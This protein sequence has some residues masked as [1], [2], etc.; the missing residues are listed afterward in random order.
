MAAQLE[1]VQ[2]T[3]NFL[4][5]TIGSLIGRS[6]VTIARHA[7]IRQ[8]LEIMDRHR[9]GSVVVVEPDTGG[10]L[11]I[12]TLQDVLT[13]VALPGADTSQ[14]ISS[15]MT[16]RI[17]ALPP[18]A[19]VQE[20]ML[21]M[22]QHG[23]QHT[24]VVNETG[25]LV[26]VVSI[27]QMRDPLNGA[28]EAF[29]RALESAEDITVLSKVAAR[30]RAHGASLVSHDVNSGV[31]T[32]FLSTINDALTRRAIDIAGAEC[33]EAPAPWCW[34]AMGSEGRFEQTFHTDQ[35]N[36]LIFRASD[37][38]DADSLRSWFVSF[39]GKINDHLAACGIPTCPG[40]IMAGNPGC[41]L[42]VEEW[43]ERFLGWIRVPEAQALLNA[44]IF[45]DFRP[46]HGD[47]AL[48]AE[49][50]QTLLALTRGNKAFLRMMAANALEVEAPI[51]TW[52]GFRTEGRGNDKYIDL[53]TYGA[54]L[55]VDV[56]RILA[57]ASG[58]AKTNTVSRLREAGFDAGMHPGDIDAAVHAF[59]ETQRIR[60]R[61]QKQGID[62]SAEDP[63]RVVPTSL[64]RF[65][66]S[67]LREAFEQAKV[68]QWRLRLNYSL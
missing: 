43:R 12:F 67:V 18:S 11:G 24:P 2:A 47:A 33:G 1:P 7:S 39:A 62:V 34:I 22:A 23:V 31:L 16:P 40:N 57:L 61:Y 44:T 54:R 14:P 49:L 35:D 32:A 37:R 9:V 25:Q 5:N 50:R 63:N 19:S 15:I 8:G 66:R 59:A 41:C 46:L 20:A 36:G 65:D 21:L 52:R 10:P 53:K 26:G 38:R 17:H 4:P 60:L 58:S 27:R 29:T 48:A 30:A 42:S 13:R 6:P 64:N 45:F 56:A 51:G 3:G 28:V 68:L 55:F